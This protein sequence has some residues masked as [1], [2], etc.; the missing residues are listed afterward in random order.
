[1]LGRI[2]WPSGRKLA[3]L[4]L[5]S[6]L[7]AT[8]GLSRDTRTVFLPT[9]SFP[10]YTPRRHGLV[11]KMSQQFFPFMPSIVSSGNYG[12][13]SMEGKGSTFEPSEEFSEWWDDWVRRIQRSRDTKLTLI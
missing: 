6:E 7:P 3:E 10:S 12:S 5:I 13:L 2:R 1:M 4:T 8:Q 9:V 11:S